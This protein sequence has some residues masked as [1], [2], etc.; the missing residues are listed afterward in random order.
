MVERNSLG[1]LD[2]H[3][4]SDQDK[5]QRYALADRGAIL[6]RHSISILLSCLPIMSNLPIDLAYLLFSD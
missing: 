6:E 2:D 5:Y 3:F 1:V 4:S